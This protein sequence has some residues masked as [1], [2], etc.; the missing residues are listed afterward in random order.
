MLSKPRPYE[1][2][3]ALA[4]RLGVSERTIW[5]WAEPHKRLVE[6]KRFGPRLGVRARLRPDLDEKF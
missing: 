6:I 4:R 2:I 5:R 1:K 3:P